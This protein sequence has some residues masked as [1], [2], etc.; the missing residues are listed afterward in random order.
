MTVATDERTFRYLSEKFSIPFD[1][2]VWYNSGICY[3]R[4]IVKTKES[5]DKVTAAVKGRTV[6]GGM[7]HDME[8]GGQTPSNREDGSVY[9]DITC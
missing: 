8:L 1:D 5:A 2:I 9:Y 3:S 7:F 4:I 6:N